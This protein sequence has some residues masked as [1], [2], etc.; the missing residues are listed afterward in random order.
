[1]LST[2]CSDCE[3]NRQLAVD[4]S[5]YA[6]ELEIKVAE[7]TEKIAALEKELAEQKKQKET[8]FWFGK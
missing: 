7:L 6:T 1:M 5:V 4:W 3:T 8:E 2:T